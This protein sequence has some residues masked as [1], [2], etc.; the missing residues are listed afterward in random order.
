MQLISYS[1]APYNI[2]LENTCI[3]P[4]LEEYP[5]KTRRH[6][7]SVNLENNI[8]NLTLYQNKQH[9]KIPTSKGAYA[10]ELHERPDY[11]RVKYT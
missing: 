9:K 2:D 3:T 4:D 8:K 10:S 11:E 6:I 7:P 1:V 5:N